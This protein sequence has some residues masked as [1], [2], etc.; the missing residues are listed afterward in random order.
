MAGLIVITSDVPG[1]ED[2]RD[3][4]Q[5]YGFD[6][7]LRGYWEAIL[8]GDPRAVLLAMHNRELPADKRAAGLREAG[9]KGT[10]LVLGR[11]APDLAVR[12]RLAEQKAWFMP[13]I[14]GPGDVVARV[15]QLLS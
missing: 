3:I 13:A 6:A 12:Q 1:A 15:R 9:Y 10:L 11:I 8:L 14:S 5:A 7:A 4:F 2:I